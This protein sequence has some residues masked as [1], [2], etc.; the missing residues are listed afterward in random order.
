MTYSRLKLEDI[1]E[2][3]GVQ[4]NNNSSLFLDAPPRTVSEHL[5]NTLRLNLELA[6]NIGTEKARSELLIMPVFA[7]LYQQASDHISLFSGVALNV[8]KERGLAGE[9]DFLLSRSSVRSIVTAPIVAVAE[10][11]RDDFTKGAAQCI[12]EMIASRIFNQRH[13]HEMPV[14]GVITNG[15]VWQFAR[16]ARED[17]VEVSGDFTIQDPA[18]IMGILWTMLSL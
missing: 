10:A 5:K 14:F 15:T 7:E 16:F 2:R 18:K 8:D 9:V 1:L 3:F 4:R 12:G 6:L 13:N 17:L 11:K